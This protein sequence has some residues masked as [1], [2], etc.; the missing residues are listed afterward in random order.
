[1]IE[2]K[3]RN[4]LAIDY[5]KELFHVLIVADGSGDKT[6]EIAKR[7]IEFGVASLYERRDAANRLLNDYFMLQSR[8]GFF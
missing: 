7:Y 3:I 2:D 6:S 8:T 5:S 1:V 4:S